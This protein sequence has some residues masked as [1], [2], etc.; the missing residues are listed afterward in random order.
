MILAEKLGSEFGRDDRVPQR[1]TEA[2][3]GRAH[4]VGPSSAI[5]C[6]LL[7]PVMLRLV[8]ATCQQHASRAFSSHDCSAAAHTRVRNTHASW[9]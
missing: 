7:L 8:N 3:V 4:S 1:P 6:G 2:D 9:S 5:S